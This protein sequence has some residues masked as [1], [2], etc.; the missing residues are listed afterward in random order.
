M[1]AA[2]FDDATIS[3]FQLEGFDHLSYCVLDV[4]RDRQIVDVLFKFDANEKIGLH[5]HVALNHML[6]IQGEHILYEPDDTI[7]EIRPTGR[8]TISPPSDDPHREGGG[9]Q[10][11][12]IFFSIRGT[13]GTMYEILDDD[14]EL[15]GTLG[16]EDFE[17]LLA[18]QKAN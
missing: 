7:K 2:N 15:I 4:D 14:L 17:N 11:V 18:G 6:V 16:M 10:D 5:R 12:V 13:T 1:M 8:Y 9:D 3:W